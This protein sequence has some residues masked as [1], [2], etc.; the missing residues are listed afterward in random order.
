MLHSFSASWHESWSEQGQRCFQE[1]CACRPNNFPSTN[2]VRRQRAHSSQAHGRCD[3]HLL[4][5]LQGPRVAVQADQCHTWKEFLK[6]DHDQSNLLAANHFSVLQSWNCLQVLYTSNPRAPG[7]PVLRS[8][9]GQALF[10]GSHAPS[11]PGILLCT[12]AVACAP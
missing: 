10:A 12:L 4:A 1:A 7:G 9:P 5:S 8:A 11:F 6:A 3:V 2:L